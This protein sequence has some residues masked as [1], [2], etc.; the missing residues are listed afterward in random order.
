M[1][2]HFFPKSLLDAE[3]VFEAERERQAA[4]FKARKEMAAEGDAAAARLAQILPELGQLNGHLIADDALAGVAGAPVM[5]AEDR[6]ASRS[7]LAALCA[8]RDQLTEKI[9]SCRDGSIALGELAADAAPCLDTARA[10]LT[11]WRTFSGQT[12]TL[13]LMHDIER[14]PLPRF[15]PKW[16]AIAEGLGWIGFNAGV[17]TLDGAPAF[18]D[19][20]Y[21]SPGKGEVDLKKDWRADPALVTLST[22]LA[23]IAR[24]AKSAAPMIVAAARE[25]R[26]QQEAIAEREALEAHRAEIGRRA[27]ERRDQ[28]AAAAQEAARWKPAPSYTA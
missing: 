16:A 25:R 14:L 22:S 12:L 9:K 1:D 24:V 23:E 6:G 4:L 27:Q 26:F 11:E 19:G 15:F 18:V 17:R 20:K 7:R 2:P 8:E 3:A 13:E 5:S 21:H 28:E 10:F